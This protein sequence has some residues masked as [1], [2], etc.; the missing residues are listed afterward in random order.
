MCSLAKWLGCHFLASLNQIPS[1]LRGWHNA[2]TKVWMLLWL[3]THAQ[4]GGREGII[5]PSNSPSHQ[6]AG[7]RK[8]KPCSPAY[9]HC[10]RAGAWQ[11]NS[12]GLAAALGAAP[13]V[14]R[15]RGWENQHQPSGRAVP[16]SSSPSPIQALSPRPLAL[17]TLKE[18]PLVL[19]E[20]DQLP[21]LPTSV[22][23]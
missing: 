1:F 22:C 9:D 16:V 18:E 14:L 17:A 20:G 12:W 3:V 21:S 13:A 6:A 10:R 11:H 8:A 19:L 5:F 4:A 15:K 23:E 2:N 7:S